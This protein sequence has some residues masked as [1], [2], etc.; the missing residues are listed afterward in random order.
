MD[1]QCSLLFI[2][3]T[4]YCFK[5]DVF[6][7]IEATGELLFKMAMFVFGFVIPTND[8][9]TAFNVNLKKDGELGLVSDQFRGRSV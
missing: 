2:E 5:I 6:R 3:I 7:N 8:K 9:F 1:F 4:F